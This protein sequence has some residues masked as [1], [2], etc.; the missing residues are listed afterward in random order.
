MQPEIE[1]K[2]FH[3]YVNYSRLT[4]LYWENTIVDRST[5]ILHSIIE[6]FTPFSDAY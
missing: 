2:I 6:K 5:Y 4:Y 1:R 3:T